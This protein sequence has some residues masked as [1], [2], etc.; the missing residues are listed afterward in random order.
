MGALNIPSYVKPPVTEVAAGVTL[1]L[2]AM[3]TRHIGQF[4][5]EVRHQYPNTE[6]VPPV[7]YEQN[8]RAPEVRLLP[9]PPLR[10][11]FMM[12]ADREYIMQIQEG[13]FLHNW[14][15]YPADATYPRYEV[16]LKRFLEVWEKYS[17]F[18]KRE[19]LGQA[20]PTGYELTYVNELISSSNTGIGELVKPLDWTQLGPQFLVD[21]PQVTNISWSFAM[22]DK[23]GA[24]NVTINRGLNQDGAGAALLMLSCQGPS[25]DAYTLKEWFDTARK[26]IVNGF[27]DLTTQTAHAVWEREA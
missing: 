5:E 12:T 26:W 25:S 22:P 27:T 14:R 23:K 15:R 3:Q 20:K 4:W 8:L 17:E 16:V 2:F 13:K 9:V 7:P 21:P 10:R 6:D 11:V 18:I 1:P 24:M 19:E